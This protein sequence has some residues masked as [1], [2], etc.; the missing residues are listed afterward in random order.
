ME[1]I[2]KHWIQH[3]DDYDTRNKHYR[4]E[5]HGGYAINVGSFNIAGALGRPRLMK[6]SDKSLL[7]MGM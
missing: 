4:D 7:T 2:D 6:D 3:T 1:E 5:D